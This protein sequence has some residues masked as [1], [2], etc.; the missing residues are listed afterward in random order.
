MF[1]LSENAWFFVNCL[2]V[3]F[4]HVSIFCS[5]STQ[6][7]YFFFLLGILA[8]CLCYMLGIFFPKLFAYGVFL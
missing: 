3:S 8:L 5:F 4:L 1:S 7:K 2:F 6:I